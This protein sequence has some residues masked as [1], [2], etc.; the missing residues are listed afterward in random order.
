MSQAVI[1]KTYTF[2]V[3][4][5]DEDLNPVEAEDP[6]II[7]FNYSQ[8]GV[9]QVLVNTTAMVPVQPEESGR[10]TYTYTLPG[11]LRHGD[12]IIGMMTAND[13]GAPGTRFVVEEVVDVIALSTVSTGG[14]R[15]QFVKGG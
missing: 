13:P 3:L 1:G 9:K 2:Q 7:I 4:F 10:F 14:L 5:L 11:S 8:A 6:E 12:V 15:T